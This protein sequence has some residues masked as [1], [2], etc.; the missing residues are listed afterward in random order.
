MCQKETQ[1]LILYYKSRWNKLSFTKKPKT[2]QWIK[3][4]KS[5]TGL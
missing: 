2:V 3:S 4:I 5:C 1:A